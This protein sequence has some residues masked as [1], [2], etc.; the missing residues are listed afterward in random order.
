[1]DVW[2]IDLVDPPTSQFGK[3]VLRQRI[4]PLSLMLWIL[5]TR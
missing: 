3:D 1:M 2:R 5:P 4:D